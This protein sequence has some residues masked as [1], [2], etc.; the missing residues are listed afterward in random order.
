MNI[1]DFGSNDSTKPDMLEEHLR[2]S[3]EHM[4]EVKQRLIFN[5]KAITLSYGFEM[6]FFVPTALQV[7]PDAFS[8]TSLLRT[9][10]NY[11]RLNAKSVSLADFLTPKGPLEDLRVSLKILNPK[12]DSSLADYETALKKFAMTAR[13]SIGSELETIA[14]NK[15]SV[16]IQTITE[17]TSILTEILNRYRSMLPLCEAIE[18]EVR[19]RAFAYCDEFISTFASKSIID[20]MAVLAEEKRQP[21]AEV[22][23]HERKWRRTHYPESFASDVVPP[24]RILFRWSL[25]KKFVNSFLY[26]EAKLITAK[27]LLLHSLYGLAAAV[28]MLVVTSVSS[29]WR[30]GYSHLSLWLL[31]GI[32]L[33]YIF[34]DRVREVMKEWLFDRFEKWIPDRRLHLVRNGHS[35]GLVKES[36][37]FINKDKLPRRIRT[38]RDDAH[39]VKYLSDRIAE[40]TL[41]YKKQVEIE[42]IGLIVSQTSNAILDMTRFNIKDFLK[43]ADTYLEE[44]PLP[45]DEKKALFKP[46]EK[47]MAEKIYHIYVARRIFLDDKTGH[48]LIRLVISSKGIKRFE[49][50]APLTF[51]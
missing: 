8:N 3:S 21:L 36:F 4:F 31:L 11:I 2:V 41:L 43:Y 18:S 34:R 17:C 44:L 50:I 5:P 16:E 9:L 7:T 37:R 35:T 46:Q 38:M 30:N 27:P 19:S 20:T 32:L 12:L 15:D 48:D 23:D 25:L 47:T 1:F 45:E 10:K 22:L 13:R 6:Y 42:N 40:T 26:L 33:G 49:E 14:R 29:S 24:E 28:S 39:T 51:E